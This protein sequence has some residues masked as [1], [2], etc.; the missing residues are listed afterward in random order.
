M[1]IRVTVD[2]SVMVKALVPPRRRTQDEL[3]EAQLDLHLRSRE[4]FFLFRSFI[5]TKRSSASLYILSTRSSSI[6]EILIVT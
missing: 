3:Y 4:I 1:A 6:I 5:E 2:T